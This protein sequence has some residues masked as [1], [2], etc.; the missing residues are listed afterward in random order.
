[1]SESS[2]L[3]AVENC[4]IRR[5]KVRIASND[6]IYLLSNTALCAGCFGNDFILK[7]TVEIALN[8]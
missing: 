7:H 2:T 3:E 1:M 5:L 6:F 4:L 8:V